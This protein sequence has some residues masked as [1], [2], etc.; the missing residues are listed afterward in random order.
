M[1]NS[2]N[3]SATAGGRPPPKHQGCAQRNALFLAQ[4]GG[5]KDA[6]RPNSRTFNSHFFHSIIRY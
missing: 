2:S 1:S 3:Y 6:P 5:L 4:S